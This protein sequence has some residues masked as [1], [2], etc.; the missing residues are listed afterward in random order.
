MKLNLATLNL[1]ATNLV[2]TNL[3]SRALRLAVFAIAAS[4][5]FF[6]A[7]GQKKNGGGAAGA[8]PAQARGVYKQ[9]CAKC[10]GLD[11]A[12]RTV[13]GEIA[14]TPNF[15]DG[16]WQRAANDKRLNA[17]IT[18]GRGGMPSFGDKLTRAEVDA[19]VAFIRGFKK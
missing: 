15:T 3:K 6:T 2:A 12:G 1:V 8:R 9:S 16:S 18:H 10:H 14:G 5:P 11:G 17:S 19:L 4:V 7:S 13:L